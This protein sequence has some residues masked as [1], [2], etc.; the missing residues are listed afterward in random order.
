MIDT[1]NDQ[2]FKWER[3]AIRDTNV[4]DF[5][6]Y[7]DV[8]ISWSRDLKSDLKR[9]RIAEYTEDKVRSSLYRPFT[10]SNLFFDRIMNE[11]V[12]IF[13]SIFPTSETERENRAICV[14]IPKEKPFACL[15]VNCIP[16]LVAIG[17]FGA[18]GQ[19]FPFYTYDE[20]GR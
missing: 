1:Y 14:N 15:M 8:K 19:C 3:Q 17:G 20:D 16:D 10:K 2:V 13:P 12:Y 4:D 9:G 7:D 5:V 6:A 11:E 18:P